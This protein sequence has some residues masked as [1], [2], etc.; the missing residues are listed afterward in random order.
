MSYVTVP[1]LLAGGLLI[2]LI[3]CVVLRHQAQAARRRTE[4]HRRCLDLLDPDL[5]SEAVATGILEV[6]A[7]IVQAPGYYLY[8]ADDSGDF[9]LAGAKVSAKGIPVGPDYSGLVQGFPDYEPP[10]S[11]QPGR[12]AV[13]GPHLLTITLARKTG[14]TDGLIRLGPF[15][16]RGRPSSLGLLEELAPVLAGVIAVPRAAATVRQEIAVSS[17]RA[18][19]HGAAA[20]LAFSIEEVMATLVRLGLR[21]LRAD[22]G[23][24]V[25]LAGPTLKASVGTSGEPT[26]AALRQLLTLT[27]GSAPT[28]LAPGVQLALG[29]SGHVV[30]F[31]VGDDARL[32]YALPNP[33]PVGAHLRAGLAT[34]TQHLSLVMRHDEL[35]SRVSQSYL[36]A[37]QGLVD[38]LDS[39]EP[40]MVGH[41]RLVAKWAR[42]IALELDLPAAEAARIHQAGLLHDVGMLAL[43]EGILFKEGQLSDQER[44]AV[45]AHPDTGAAMLEGVPDG[46]LLAPMVRFHHER[47]DGWGYP[48]RLRGEA[49]PLAARIIAL[50]EV[51]VAKFSRRPYRPPLPFGR[52]LSDMA[53]SGGSHFDP[54]VVQ[55]LLR[56]IERKQRLAPEG[57]SLEPCWE[58]KQCPVSVKEACPAAASTTNCW[59]VARVLCR[60]HGDEDCSE[61]MVWT[62][63]KTRPPGAR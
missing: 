10:L 35:Y 63:L 22:T 60:A 24:L 33:G 5:R 46:A 26:E 27:P 11:L 14:Q 15:L 17:S 1:A 50:A 62:E 34:V 55:A 48:D 21:L 25:S 20:R 9:L 4:L 61:C 29:L 23:L 19:A 38:V 45:Q 28:T 39:R 36:H 32:F 40:H 41:S 51:F 37:L 56:R 42:E 58:L 3:M 53:N 52:V 16:R 54:Q 30:A 2:A 31:G 59:R 44:K 57:R 47:W 49:I 43:D 7:G 18:R 12:L 8:L 13:T 6:V